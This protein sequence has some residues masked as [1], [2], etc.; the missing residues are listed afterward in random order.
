[1][2]PAYHGWTMRRRATAS[3]LPPALVTLVGLLL[4][5]C[6]DGL[7]AEDAITV[8]PSIT[9]I[10]S[11]TPL[12]HRADCAAIRGSGRY[13]NRSERDWFLDNC[14]SMPLGYIGF[15]LLPLQG[16]RLMEI[17]EVPMEVCPS[18]Y[19]NTAVDEEINGEIF[20]YLFRTFCYAARLANFSQLP[21][22]LSCPPDQTMTAEPALLLYYTDFKR[23]VMEVFCVGPDPTPTPTP[24]PLPVSTSVAPSS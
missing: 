24:I 19:A 3:L 22:P 16:S 7:Y 11:P 12:A 15:N 13:V 17:Y 23:T 10:P 8:T 2:A 9:A 5:A 21:P 6:G 4:L 1:M 14:A 20:S 18:G